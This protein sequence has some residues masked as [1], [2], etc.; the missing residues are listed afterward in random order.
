[1]PQG[2]LHLLSVP[3]LGELSLCA[4]ILVHVSEELYVCVRVGVYLHVYD[5]IRVENTYTYIHICL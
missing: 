3:C 4:Y 1:M 2:L 5:S